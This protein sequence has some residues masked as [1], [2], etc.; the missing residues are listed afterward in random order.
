MGTWGVAAGGDSESLSSFSPRKQMAFAASVSLL[1][2][3]A[4]MDTIGVIGTSSLSYSGSGKWAFA[5]AC[6]LVSWLW[7]FGLSLAGRI[8]GKIDQSR[9]FILWLN[10]ISAIIMW[11]T[12]IY[13]FLTLFK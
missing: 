9:S 11:G 2:P 1:N 8:I 4:I 12:A 10:K 13:L 7:F 5:I 3:H 6:I